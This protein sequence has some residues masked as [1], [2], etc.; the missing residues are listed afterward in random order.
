MIRKP[1]AAFGR[2][3]YA[4]YYESGYTVEAVTSADSKTVL[5]F[6]DGDL[7]VRDK[8]TGAVVDQCV[9]GWIRY[10]DYD[11]RTIVVTANADSVS[12]CY[13]PK[14]NNDDAPEIE[15]FKLNQGE[16][17]NLVA[18]ENLFLCKGTLLVNQNQYI[19]PYQIAVKTEGNTAVAVTDI[20]GLLFK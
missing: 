16:S 12:W 7:N 5:M 18:N 17:V 14:A 15:L 4:N 8:Q 3:L 1:F 13:D 19:G 2:V 20:Y 9:P 11:N 10:G 6:S